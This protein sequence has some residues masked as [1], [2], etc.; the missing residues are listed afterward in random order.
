MKFLAEKRAKQLRDVSGFK[1]AGVYD[2]SGVGGTHVMYV[3]HDAK[4]PERYGGL[5]ANPHI[6][7][8]VQLWKH[9]LKWIGNFGIIAGAVGIFAHYLRFGPKIVKEDE[10]GGTPGG[11]P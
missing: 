4:N 1:D 11:K 6:P 5:P 2:P 7:W 3:L 9:P 10:K 8:T